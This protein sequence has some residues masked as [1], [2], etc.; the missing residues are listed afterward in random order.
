MGANGRHQPLQPF[1]QEELFGSLD[2]TV[3]EDDYDQ[4][5]VF[6]FKG[7]VPS[8]ANYDDYFLYNLT[9]SGNSDAD[10]TLAYPFPT[11]VTQLPSVCVE[12][13]VAGVVSA[14]KAYDFIAY[15]GDGASPSGYMDYECEGYSGGKSLTT[16]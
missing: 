5:L 4:M 12:R 2:I 13:R 1:S 15:A 16:S 10:P 9:K 7:R 8:D 14:C 6:P 11:A 3:L